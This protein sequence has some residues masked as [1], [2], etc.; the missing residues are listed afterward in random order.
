M[1]AV[2]ISSKK[3]QEETV[4]VSSTEERRKK[5]SNPGEFAPFISLNSDTGKPNNGPLR[6]IIIKIC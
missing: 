6:I 5:K 3:K 1:E 2:K 4:E